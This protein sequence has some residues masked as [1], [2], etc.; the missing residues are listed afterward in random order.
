MVLTFKEAYIFKHISLNHAYFVIR[1]TNSS[2][3][4]SDREVL[5]TLEHYSKPLTKKLFSTMVIGT[6]A[7][8]YTFAAL[9]VKPSL[10]LDVV[11]CY[12]Q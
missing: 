5:V 12:D 11:V 6:W 10:C 4:Y 1:W 3:R 7:Y 2:E 9:G 8:F